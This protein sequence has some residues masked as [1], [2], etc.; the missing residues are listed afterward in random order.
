M[1]GARPGLGMA[2]LALLSI[3]LIVV[4]G[5]LQ[6]DDEPAADPVE[7]G[8]PEEAAVRFIALGD[9]GM[10][11]EDQARV[12]EA[13]ATVCAQRGCDFALGLGDLIYPSGATSP[14]D[15][16]FDEKF[17]V[18]YAGLDF[19]FWNVLGNHD[20]GQDP[21]GATEPAGGLGLWYT[22][23]DNEVAYAKRTDRASDKWTM[24]GRHYTFDQG[25]VHFVGLDT[26][27]L[28]FYGVPTSPEAVARLQEQEE[29]L[30]GAVAAGEGPWRIAFGHHP[31]VSNGPHGNAGDWD[32]LPI[33]GANGDHFKEVFEASLCDRVD[34][35]LAGHD[36]N[37]QWLEPVDACGRTHFIVSGGGG[38]STYELPGG[39]AARFEAESL[40][41]WWIEVQGD[42][43]TAAAFDDEATLL[44]EEPI[45]KP[46]A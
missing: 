42:T 24:P 11:N 3:A 30:P 19:P 6:P 34:L 32:G 22:A 39:G 36:H 25:P 13:V 15:P 2:R 35:Y 23:G 28:V 33:P 18:P 27:T 38:A 20:N 9:M 46:V 37:L 1:G 21:F 44:H 29:W 31:Y 43:L 12:A 45:A 17:E 26:N 14:D 8:V 41:F 4:A 7:D 5:C 10:G 40:G 16:Q